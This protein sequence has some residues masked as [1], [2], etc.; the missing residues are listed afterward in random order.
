MTPDFGVIFLHHFFAELKKV[1]RTTMM[2]EQSWL[3]TMTLRD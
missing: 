1:G 3:V 2:R